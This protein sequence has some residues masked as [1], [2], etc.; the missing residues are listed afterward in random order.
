MKPCTNTL[1]GTLR[2]RELQHRRPEQRVEVDDVLADEVIL[3]DVGSAM[4]SSNVRVSP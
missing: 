3:L 2:A 1:F 4:N